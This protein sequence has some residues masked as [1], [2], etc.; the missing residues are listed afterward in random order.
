MTISDTD[1]SYV[2]GLMDQADFELFR[3]LNSRGRSQIP[4]SEI[5]TSEGVL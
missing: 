2:A 5:K 3:A 4:Q 1:L